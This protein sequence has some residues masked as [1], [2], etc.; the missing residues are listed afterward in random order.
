MP[1]PSRK[2]ERTVAPEPL[3]ATIIT[4]MSF[5][6]TQPVRSFQVMAKP[7][8]KYSV[9]PGV[10]RGLMRGH[11]LITAASE[12]RQRMMSPFAAASSIPKSVSP[13]TQP[14]ATALS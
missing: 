3:G 13:G 11:T 5:G 1:R 9:L 4:S 2:R 6:G 12:S 10:S 14:S 7:W 8:E